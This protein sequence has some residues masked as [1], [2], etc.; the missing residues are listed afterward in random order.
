MSRVK[1]DGAVMLGI[2]EDLKKYVMMHV[3]DGAL[4]G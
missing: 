3:R 1:R 2:A 4:N